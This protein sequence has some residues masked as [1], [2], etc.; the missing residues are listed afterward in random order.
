MKFVSRHPILVSVLLLAAILLALILG[1]ALWMRYESE[2]HDYWYSIVITTPAVLE[3]CTFILPVPF[4]NNRSILGEAM[5]RGEVYNLPP[6]WRLSLE[7]VNSTPMLKIIAPEIVPEYHGYPIPIEW[8]STPSLTPPPAATAWSEETPVL[9]S[10]QVGISQRVPESIDTQN[11]I[12][13]EPL[14]S[15]PELYVPNP[16]R[17]PFPAGKCYR[18]MAPVFMHCSP[19][20][21][22]NATLSIASGGS[23]Q[24]WVLGWSGNSYDETIEVTPMED[25]AGWVMGDG[26]LSTGV[27]RY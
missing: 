23:N 24:W 27:G 13:R 21:I 4:T 19:T 14:L 10:L 17:G 11:P 3:N 16:C 15:Y 20:G 2:S 25:Q 8:G 18:Y 6:D 7:Q 9:I 12:N 1:G 26:F 22:H 5:V